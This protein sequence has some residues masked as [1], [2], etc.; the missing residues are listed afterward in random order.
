[1]FIVGAILLGSVVENDPNNMVVA[2]KT[3]DEKDKMKIA[4]IVLL[5]VG[6]VGMFWMMNKMKM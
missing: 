6:L 3:M 2:G 4:G 1:M 5:C